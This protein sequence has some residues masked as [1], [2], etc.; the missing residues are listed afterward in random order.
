MGG[1]G[2]GRAGDD[3]R[4]RVDLEHWAAFRSSFEAVAHLLINLVAG[5]FGLPPTSVGFLSGD[6]HYSYLARAPLPAA[7]AS[8][9]TI[10]YPVV[11]SP[12][13]N[14]LFGPVR[15]L[16]ACASSVVAGLVGRAL[17][18]TTRV[19][20][21]PF[22]WTVSSGPA[23]ATSSTAADRRR[24]DRRALDG[25]ERQ[26][27]RPSPAARDQHRTHPLTADHQCSRVRDALTVLPAY[28]AADP[29][30]P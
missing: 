13:R 2:P 4:R 29:R 14:P 19:S 20:R 24:A 11:C 15:A 12:I 3:G 1:Y 27:P 16:N 9:A 18:R 6:L 26:H 22:D 30:N 28:H 7:A 23:S 21:S 8:S 5:R 25:A 10:V 17:A